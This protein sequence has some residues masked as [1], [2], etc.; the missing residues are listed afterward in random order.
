MEKNVTIVKTEIVTINTPE[1]KPY[2]SVT[3]E[4]LS[5]GKVIRRAPKGYLLFPVSVETM[6]SWHFQSLDPRLITTWHKG[7]KVERCY[8]FPVKKDMYYKFMRPEWRE[9][10]KHERECKCMVT[11]QNGVPM[12]CPKASCKGCPNAGKKMELC[13]PIPLD[14]VAGNI[15]WLV[16]NGFDS[17]SETAIGHVMREQFLD[18]LKGIEPKLP[19]IAVLLDMGYKAKKIAAMLGINKNTLYS[20]IKR[21]RRLWKKFNA[22]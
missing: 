16:H 19:K 17:T 15:D 1:G 10:K 13:A 18:Y 2:S 6:M 14:T 7:S 21:I 8:M 3:L 22:D 20:D 9:V 11:G 4:T 12:R 5:N